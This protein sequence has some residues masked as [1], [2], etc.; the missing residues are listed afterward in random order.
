MRKDAA[1]ATTLISVGIVN[2]F[3]GVLLLQQWVASHLRYAP[4]VCYWLA[5]AAT[6]ALLWWTIYYTLTHEP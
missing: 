2:F 6:F 3:L 4:I 5:A 1:I